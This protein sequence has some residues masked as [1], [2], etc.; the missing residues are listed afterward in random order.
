[1][2]LLNST[3]GQLLLTNKDT[4]FVIKDVT[5]NTMIRHSEQQVLETSKFARD[6][7]Y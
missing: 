7:L 1:M 5:G 6:S 4:Y 3:A 2:S